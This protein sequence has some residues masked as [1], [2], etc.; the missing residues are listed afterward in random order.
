MKKILILVLLTISY[1]SAGQ[2]LYDYRNG[3]LKG[4]R[5]ACNCS[6]NPPNS[7]KLYYYNGTYKDGYN[8]GY[9]DGRIFVSKNSSYQEKQQFYQP[10]YNL[11]YNAL[12][13]KQELLDRRRDYLHE[14]YQN[15]MN[16]INSK[17]NNRNDKKI[18][19]EEE[20]NIKEFKSKL[21]VYINYD[22]TNSSTYNQ[23]INWMQD[24]KIYFMKW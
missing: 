10:D 5:K 12:K 23:I 13:T 15:I 8:A 4:F 2:Q 14:E 3:Y 11:L 24:W 18:T 22:L 19:K 6:N 1:F 7:D 21:N 9:T 16:L 20:Q 17:V